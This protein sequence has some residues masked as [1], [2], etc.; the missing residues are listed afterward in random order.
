[1]MGAEAIKELLR[2]VEI[3]ELSTIDRA[4]VAGSLDRLCDMLAALRPGRLALIAGDEISSSG[5]SAETVAL[6]E[7]FGAPV[8]GS[9]WP[10]HIPFPTAHPLWRGNLPTKASE[11]RAILE[12]YDAVFALGGKSL[13]TILYSEGPAVPSGCKI[14]QLSSDVRDLGRTYATELSC[15]GDIRASLVALLPMLERKLAHHQGAIAALR[16]RA[17]SERQARRAALRDRADCESQAAV[18]TPFVAAAEVVRAI[19]PHV[20]IV[21]EAP[22]TM[23]DV[24]SLL[25]SS[26]ARQY[27]ACRGG[28]LGWGMPAAVGW[29]LGLDR[30]PVVSLVGDG[31]SMYSPQALWT[32][33]YERLPVTFVVMNNREYNILKTFSK[34]QPHYLSPRLNRFIAMDI[35]DPPIDFLAL[36]AAMGVPA[37][38]VARAADIASAVEDGIASNRANLIEIPISAT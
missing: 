29:S 37:R 6:A 10:A 26:F 24:R 17:A 20:A 7:A 34:S 1:M 3:A 8:F 16:D 13:I 32:A 31:S 18:T 5:A 12:S 15:M 21:D 25:E 11:I 19:G 38:R 28:G 30:Q 33:A 22:A 35:S 23:V 36:A 27:S 2:R 9:S 4:A 14:F